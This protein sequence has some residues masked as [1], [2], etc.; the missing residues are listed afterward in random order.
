[1][2]GSLPGRRT[3]IQG[4][5]CARLKETVARNQCIIE[6]IKNLQALL[7]ILVMGNGKLAEKVDQGSKRRPRSSHPGKQSTT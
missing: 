6:S 1:M 5:T 2:L 3:C 4:P 7:A